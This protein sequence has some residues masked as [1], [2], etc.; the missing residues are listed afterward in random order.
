MAHKPNSA[1]LPPF[2]LSPALSFLVVSSDTM[3]EDVISEKKIKFCQ[4]ELFQKIK[5]DKIVG[6]ENESWSSLGR[7][8]HNRHIWAGIEWKLETYCKFFKQN[9]NDIYK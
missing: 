9:Y 6:S 5:L 8:I 7:A 2:T 3:A 4:F 1:E